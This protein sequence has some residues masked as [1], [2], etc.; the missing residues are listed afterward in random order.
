MALGTFPLLR[1]S[2][3]AQTFRSFCL[4]HTCLCTD[5][6]SHSVPS[7]QA[8]S[9]FL[10]HGLLTSSRPGLQALFSTKQC[11][12]HGS[13]SLCHSSGT[14]SRGPCGRRLCI[15]FLTNLAKEFQ[16]TSQ[17]SGLHTS[18]LCLLARGVLSAFSVSR[19]PG[20]SFPE[21]LLPGLDISCLSD[22]AAAPRSESAV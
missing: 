2:A 1:G 20:P 15:H 12:T 9:H 21:M 6:N 18:G 11:E 16:I 7:V 14:W 17:T 13:W 5:S 10:S 22:M 8:K 19:P 3:A 4:S